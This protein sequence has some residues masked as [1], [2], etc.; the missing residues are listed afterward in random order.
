MKMSTLAFHVDTTGLLHH[1]IVIMDVFQ[2]TGV[3][4]SLVELIV[5]DSFRDQFLPPA[6]MDHN[7]IGQIES[8]TFFLQSEQFLIKMLPYHKGKAEK[9]NLLSPELLQEFL[10]AFHVQLHIIVKS[11]DLF[12]SEYGE[13]QNTCT[14]S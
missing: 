2:T 4:Q 11:I 9:K 12:R 5:A 8:D 3:F 6:T 1:A 7:S 13:T 14:A 10:H